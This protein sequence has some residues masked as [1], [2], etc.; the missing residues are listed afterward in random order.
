MKFIIDF[1]GFVNVVNNE[2]NIFLYLVMSYRFS[3]DGLCV[4]WEVL[5]VLL[6]GGVYVDMVNKDR[7]RV[8]DVV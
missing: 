2:I 6:N 3:F 7:K 5:E 8:M 4:L 1:G